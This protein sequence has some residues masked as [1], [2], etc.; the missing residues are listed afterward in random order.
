MDVQRMKS[1]HIRSD[2]K[3]GVDLIRDQI[4]ILRASKLFDEE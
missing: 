3:T 4:N 1:L 2:V